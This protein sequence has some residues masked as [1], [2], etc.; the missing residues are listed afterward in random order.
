MNRA[1]SIIKRIEESNEKATKAIPRRE[2][3]F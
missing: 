3:S 2:L 1:E